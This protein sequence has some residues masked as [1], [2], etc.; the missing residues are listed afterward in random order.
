ML[1]TGGEE[2][3]RDGMI[4][5]RGIGAVGGGAKACKRAMARRTGGETRRG[6]ATTGLTLP[7]KGRAPRTRSRT[8]APPWAGTLPR[9]GKITAGN[10]RGR[11]VAQTRHQQNRQPAWPTLCRH[12][13]RN[14][15]W[16]DESETGRPRAAPLASSRPQRGPATGDS[17]DRHV[18]LTELSPRPLHHRDIE[19]CCRERA[20]G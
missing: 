15:A 3:E 11:G 9:P 20:G 10:N 18:P 17:R 6:G 12:K 14:G 5:T 13:Y 16:T 19:E 8:P 2:A 4:K 1:R 7:I